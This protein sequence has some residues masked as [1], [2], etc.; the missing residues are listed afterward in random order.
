MKTNMICFPT[1]H[2][3]DQRTVKLYPWSAMIDD[4]CHK[5][6]QQCLVSIITERYVTNHNICH[7]CR[8]W[9]L[10][11]G[12]Q[13]QTEW[14]PQDPTAGLP[15]ICELSLP[16]QC[17]ALQSPYKSRLKALAMSTLSIAESYQYNAAQEVVDN[18]FS[19]LL[20]TAKVASLQL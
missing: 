11:T 17:L 20:P 3:N 4:F 13:E 5:C 18:V 9:L 2:T 10:F 8:S 7:Q 14:G 15:C 12:E 16:N 6:F 1:Y 19:R